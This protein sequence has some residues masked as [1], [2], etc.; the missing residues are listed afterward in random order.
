[1]VSVTP[2]LY[3]LDKTTEYNTLQGTMRMTIVTIILIINLYSYA[4]NSY[5]N[6]EVS[7]SPS[8]GVQRIKKLYIRCPFVEILFQQVNIE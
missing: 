3:Q 5:L 1:M 7:F 4:L 8:F 2:L 6:P